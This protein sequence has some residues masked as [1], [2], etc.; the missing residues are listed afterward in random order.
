MKTSS[1]FSQGESHSRVLMY[2]QHICVQAALFSWW[3]VVRNTSPNW[4]DMIYKERKF[5]TFT[6]ESWI[7]YLAFHSKLNTWLSLLQGLYQGVA[8]AMGSSQM[9]CINF[10]I[11][12]FSH[13]PQIITYPCVSPPHSP[14]DRWR[15]RI[16]HDAP[17]MMV[18]PLSHSSLRTQMTFLSSH[19]WNS[20]FISTLILSTGSPLF[21]NALS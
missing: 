9:Y 11:L 6:E 8:G 3:R 5:A 10:S 15:I 21:I 18:I 20:D 4:E 14:S 17:R 12:Q 2:R 19:R 13:S 16:K 1:H 7:L